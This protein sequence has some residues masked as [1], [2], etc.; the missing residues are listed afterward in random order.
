MA[1]VPATVPIP[2]TDMAARILGHHTVDEESLASGHIGKVDRRTRLMT[3]SPVSPK[4]WRTIASPVATRIAIEL[5]APFPASRHLAR[6]GR[7]DFEA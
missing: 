4:Y 7:R 3:H 6:R 5:P 2:E 1:I